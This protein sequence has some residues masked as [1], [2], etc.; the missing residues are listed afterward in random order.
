M[1]VIRC[2]SN[3]RRDYTKEQTEEDND[4]LFHVVNMVQNLHDQFPNVPNTFDSMFDDAKKSLF[5]GYKRSHFNMLCP[6]HPKDQIF[7]FCAFETY[8]TKVSL[9]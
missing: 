1:K 5:L 8:K 2:D 4:N 3:N 9:R 6:F 7:L